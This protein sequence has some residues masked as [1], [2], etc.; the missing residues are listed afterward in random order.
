MGTA[1]SAGRGSFRK[2]AR[3]RPH[4]LD[5]H[6]ERRRGD[7]PLGAGDTFAA[8]FGLALAAGATTPSA[9]ELASAAASVVVREHP[10]RWYARRPS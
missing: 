1:H 6:H 3:G 8:A 10:A 2:L 9:A 7:L 5:E 4:G